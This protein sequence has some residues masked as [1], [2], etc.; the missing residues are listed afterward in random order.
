M[1]TTGA[2]W[3]SGPRTFSE[4]YILARLIGQRLER[5]GYQVE[6]RD[7]LGSAV[8]FGAVSTGA[9]DVYVDYAGTIWTNEMKRTDVPAP[10]AMLR[11]DR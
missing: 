7:G 3:W 2:R 4:Q 1:A 10:E 9:I 6:Y 5:A 8:I 11:G